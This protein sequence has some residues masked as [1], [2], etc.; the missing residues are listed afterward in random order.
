VTG[1]NNRR[2]KLTETQV[3]GI[4]WDARSR[5]VIAKEHGISTTMVTKIKKGQAWK[6]VTQAFAIT[7]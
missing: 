7:D 1:S 6:H 4:Y 2:S 3:A 5:S